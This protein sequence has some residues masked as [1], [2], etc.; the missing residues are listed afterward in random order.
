MLFPVIFIDFSDDGID[1]FD[2]PNNFDKPFFSLYEFPS[3]GPV[4]LI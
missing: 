4:L 3:K 1:E 2:P